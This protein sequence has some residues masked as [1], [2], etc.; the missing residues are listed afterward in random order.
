MT[1]LALKK[2]I[3]A[4]FIFGLFLVL[5]APALAEQTGTYDVDAFKAQ[6]GLDTSANTAG[7]AVGAGAS[8]LQDLVG[9]AIY[10]LLSLVGVIFL[11]LIIFGAF[12]W[13]TAEGNE[14][15]V[16][17]ANKIL[18]GSLFGFVIVVAA[19]AVTYFVLTYLWK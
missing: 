19:Y 11:G 5:T 3:S 12:T 14:Q 7:Y 13:M 4:T 6:S 8:S 16:A 2:I 10:S 18:M 9:T 1:K 17:Q 15:K